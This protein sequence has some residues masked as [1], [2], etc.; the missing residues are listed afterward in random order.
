M[1]KGKKGVKQGKYYGI[2][3]QMINDEDKRL[4]KELKTLEKQETDQQKLEQ[5]K[6]KI[7]AERKKFYENVK[8]LETKSLGLIDAMKKVRA[9][10]FAERDSDKTV[11]DLTSSNPNVDEK[12]TRLLD[13]CRVPQAYDHIEKDRMWGER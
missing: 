8:K 13:V 12:S 11:V 2:T 6:E 3:R 5:G 4:N 1:A 10:L 9:P 7:E